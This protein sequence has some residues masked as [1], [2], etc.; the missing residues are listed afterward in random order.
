MKHKRPKLERFARW[1]CTITAAASALAWAF[2]GVWEF[3]AVTPEIGGGIQVRVFLWSG[4]IVGECLEDRTAADWGWTP[5]IEIDRADPTYW[6]RMW[7]LP[8][9]GGSSFRTWIDI[10]L[11]LPLSLFGITSAV[12]WRRHLRAARP[13]NACPACGY[14]RS[15]LAATT[16]CPECGAA[17]T[18]P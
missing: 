3:A 12:L 1:A 8:S 11:W 5:T 2:T 4:R 13:V 15:G 9:A 10:P 17:P 14:D 18:P 7:R 16:P 6:T